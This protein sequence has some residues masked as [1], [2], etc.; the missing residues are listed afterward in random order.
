MKQKKVSMKHQCSSKDMNQRR[1]KTVFNTERNRTGQRH[2]DGWWGTY[3]NM[4]NR[5]GQ[6]VWINAGSLTVKGLSNQ[7]VKPPC[8]KALVACWNTYPRLLQWSFH[9]VLISTSPAQPQLLIILLQYYF[10]IGTKVLLM[11]FF[12]F[13]ILIG[14]LYWRYNK[15]ALESWIWQIWPK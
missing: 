5:A 10:R 8:L 7:T 13:T 9:Y 14:L 6:R 12:F 2:G 3:S 15:L 4:I 11:F 1:N